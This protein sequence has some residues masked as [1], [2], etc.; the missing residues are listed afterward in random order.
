MAVARSGR[1]AGHAAG[2]RRGGRPVLGLTDA[3]ARGFAVPLHVD[4]HRERARERQRGDV[5]GSTCPYPVYFDDGP[6]QLLGR[7]AITGNVRGRDDVEHATT[8]T[9]GSV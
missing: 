7:R 1:T 9:P 4:P 3:H 6:R 5:D 2:D 8:T